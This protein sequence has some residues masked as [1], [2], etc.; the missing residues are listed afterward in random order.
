MELQEITQRIKIY[1][2][3]SGSNPLLD[4]DFR[5]YKGAYQNIAIDI[6][7]P[8]SVLSNVDNTHPASV[9]TAMIVTQPNGDKTTTISYNAELSAEN[10]TSSATGNEVVYNVYS[11]FLP[12]AFVQVAGEQQLVANV[13]LMDATDSE[14]PIFDRIITSQEVELTIQYS[15]YIDN[16][17]V[18]QPSQYEYLAGLIN[19]KQD[20]IADE[21]GNSIIVGGTLTTQSVV[22]SINELNTQVTQNTSDINDTSN[23][24]KKRVSDIEA[25]QITQNE[26]ISS[27]TREIGTNAGN[28]STLQ[29]KVGNLEDIVGSGEDY[30]GTY[31][32]TY[33]PNNASQLE[34]LK[35]L[36]TA[37][38]KSTRGNDYDVQGGD[39][40]IYVQQVSGGTDRNYKFIYSGSQD[41][42]TFY[43][44]PATEKAENDTYGIVKGSTS[45]DLQVKIASGIFTD[46][47]VKDNNNTMKGVGSY[48]NDI[49]LSLANNI[50]QTNT[51]K[52]NIETNTDNISTLQGQMSNV[53]D[54]TTAVG[55]A[56]NAVNDGN[57]NN[58]VLEYAYNRSDSRYA[59]K[60]QKCQ[61][62][63]T[64]NS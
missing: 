33:D 47:Q 63:K 64:Y 10:V 61:Q 17:E 49:E 16:E 24:L 52:D 15:D 27:N 9:K 41:D 51:N 28:I 60:N 37:Y 39:V 7:V 55:K 42:W 3:E 40:V 36:I 22:T 48:L 8:T 25:E 34:T 58:I 46:I 44:I 13:I 18:V 6:Y 62:C 4:Y 50:S 35:P 2:K 5:I 23:G 29:T 20:K 19:Q 11:Q 32:D 26:N 12:R 43:E 59:Y 56:T 38:V 1:L 30:I 21:V 54:G 45:G 53:L 14:N 57:G 31:T